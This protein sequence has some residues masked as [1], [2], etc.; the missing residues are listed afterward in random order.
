MKREV[1]IPVSVILVADCDCK[2]LMIAHHY[3][4]GF[5]IPGERNI[6][7]ADPVT[8]VQVFSLG[9]VATVA[10]CP[11]QPRCSPD[12]LVPVVAGSVADCKNCVAFWVV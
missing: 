9:Q 4:R 5:C 2:A 10:G 7:V 6:P 8:I 3:S 12:Q 1:V 11:V